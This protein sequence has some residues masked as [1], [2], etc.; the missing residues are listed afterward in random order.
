VSLRQR[1]VAPRELLAPVDPGAQPAPEEEERLVLLVVERVEV[2][3]GVLL[4]APIEGEAE[5]LADLCR[6]LLLLFD[7]EVGILD[8]LQLLLARDLLLGLGLLLLLHRA[9]RLRR[10]RHPL[11]LALLPERVPHLLHVRLPLLALRLV[12]E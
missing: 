5:L 4:R 11:L 9:R 2:G 6:L 10:P 8:L 12:H 3:G 7:A 1:L